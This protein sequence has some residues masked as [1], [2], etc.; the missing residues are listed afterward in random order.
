MAYGET[1]RNGM[2]T[3]HAEVPNHVQYLFVGASV[4]KREGGR[5]RGWNQQ[6]EII[7]RVQRL[8]RTH[9]LPIGREPAITRRITV[10]DDRMPVRFDLVTMPAVVIQGRVVDSV[11][12]EPTK[13]AWLYIKSHRQ[14]MNRSSDT[15]EFEILGVP[16]GLDNEIFAVVQSEIASR[17]IHGA[18]LEHDLRIDDWRL[19]EKPDGTI[20]NVR[21]KGTPD[22]SRD[23]LRE[24]RGASLSRGA[25]FISADGAHAH[26]YTEV[27]DGVIALGDLQT[28]PA[29]LPPG[30]YFVAPG[31]FQARDIQC[32]LWDAIRA[33]IDV[34]SFGVAKLVVGEEA[35]AERMTIDA[36]AL[37]KAIRK[38][39]ASE[40]RDKQPVQTQQACN[41]GAQDGENASHG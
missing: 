3:L 23:R 27:D 37:A 8:E 11:R 29:T 20:I 34:E 2:V 10:K 7:R 28:A 17:R 32:A 13:G 30:E 16:K 15:G 33:G 19:P 1:D 12:Q 14:S 18:N 25:T 26:T 24:G 40:L 36:I 4:E 31:Y 22:L 5:T 6:L 39:M 35:A 21:M 41:E 9:S 38:I